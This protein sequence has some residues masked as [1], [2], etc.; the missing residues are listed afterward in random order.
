MENS[1]GD[2]RSECIGGIDLG[3]ILE[4]ILVV[5]RMMANKGSCR[6]KTTCNGIG[7]INPGSKFHY[8]TKNCPY[9]QS[10]KLIIFIII[11]LN[12]Y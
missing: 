9:A 6:Y 2:I 10:K 3:E 8:I 5:P 11:F 4:K 12:F 1:V 7:N